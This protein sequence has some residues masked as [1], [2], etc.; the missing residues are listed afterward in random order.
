LKAGCNDVD[1][2]T[3]TSILYRGQHL[4]QNMLQGGM[5][6]FGLTGLFSEIL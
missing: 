3:H 2:A 1:V 5:L 6:F 4:I